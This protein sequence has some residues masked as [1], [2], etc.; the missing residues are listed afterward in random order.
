MAELPEI[1]EMLKKTCRDFADHKLKPVAA[2]LD[3]NHTYP[4]ELVKEMGQLGLMAVEVTEEDGGTGLDALAYAIAMEEISRGCAS[5]G[6]IMSAHNSLYLGPVQKWGNAAQKEKFLRPFLSGDKI[7]CFALSEPDNGSDAGAAKTLAVLDGDHW[8]LNGTKAW[9]TNSF[10]AEACVLFATTNKA[11]K[12]KGISAFLVPMK[13]PGLTLGKKEDKLGIRASSTCNLIFE[14]CRIPKDYLLGELGLGFKIAMMTLDAG[15]IGVAGQALGIAQASLDVAVNYAEKRLAFGVPISKLQAIQM[16]IADMATRLE[17]ARLLTWKAAML[18]DAKKD[19]TK[20]AAMAKL[21]SSETATFNAHQAI[22]ILGG[23]GYVSDMPA[24]RYYRDAR[25]TEIYEGTSEIQRLVIAGKVFKD[26]STGAPE[27]KPRNGRAEKTLISLLENKDGRSLFMEQVNFT[28]LVRESLPTSYIDVRPEVSDANIDIMSFPMTKTYEAVKEKLEHEV[29]WKFK[30]VKPSTNNKPAIK[31][32]KRKKEKKKKPKEAKGFQKRGNDHESETQQKP[33]NSC[34]PNVQ[35]RHVA[36]ARKGRAHSANRRLEG[37]GNSDSDSDEDKKAKKDQYAGLPSES[38]SDVDKKIA[39]DSGDIEMR[40]LDSC[41]IAVKEKHALIDDED[42]VNTRVFAR[43]FVGSTTKTASRI[44]IP[45]LPHC[46][47]KSEIDCRD[48]EKDCKI[49]RGFLAHLQ[50]CPELDCPYCNVIRIS[51]F[52]HSVTCAEKQCPV[53]ECNY[54]KN[55]VAQECLKRTNARATKAQVLHSTSTLWP[56]S[57]IVQMNLDYVVMWSQEIGKGKFGIVE[58]S[59]FFDMTKQVEADIIIKKVKYD[60][61]KEG[62]I[63][64]LLREDHPNILAAQV[65]LRNII[66]KEGIQGYI[67]MERAEGTLFDVKKSFPDQRIALKLTIYYG[68]QLFDGLAFLHS[69]GICHRDIKDLNLLV[70]EQGQRLKIADWDAAIIVEQH[71]GYIP[72]KG[73][74]GFAAPE[75]INDQPH[76]YP[77]DIF[78]AG[79]T[80]LEIT[81]GGQYFK[82]NDSEKSYTKRRKDKLNELKAMCPDLENIISMCLEGD[83]QERPTALEVKRHPIFK[84]D[85]SY[86]VQLP[87][88]PVCSSQSNQAD[89]AV[90]D[91]ISGPVG[92]VARQR[93]SE[94]E[95][96]GDARI[97]EMLENLP[98]KLPSENIPISHEWVESSIQEMDYEIS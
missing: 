20:E 95:N 15:R 50:K 21:A 1:H 46:S 92:E 23:M 33:P 81:V 58:R 3:R 42:I 74:R 32:G 51:I 60:P 70:A 30:E 75:V 2:D 63:H 4:G 11:K 82:G 53:P 43:L 76:S 5:S 12:H 10:E 48:C 78:S 66:P 65:V 31:D 40:S 54:Y 19:F 6:V 77:A 44:M 97:L 55:K 89:S 8:V 69:K 41:N 90:F 14:D 85:P 38:D 96:T 49:T 79:V 29:A 71:T 64:E 7:G 17:S 98:K 28:G 84:L 87:P 56:K 72:P 45:M 35:K 16:K 61:T 36:T 94:I 37:I 24:E 52:W 9:I 91:D 67:L 80:L 47:Y 88:L 73:T 18:K 59:W 13:T 68:A 62:Y 93:S 39:T 83:P 34:Q 57:Q 25:I 22:Q 27:Q 86:K 26:T